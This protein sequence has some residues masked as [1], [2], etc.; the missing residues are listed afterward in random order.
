[1]EDASVVH[2]CFTGK[3][4]YDLFCVFD[5]HGSRHSAAYCAQHL[6]ERLAKKLK[7]GARPDTALRD[8]FVQVFNLSSCVFVSSVFRLVSSS[9]LLSSLT[10]T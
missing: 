3:D 10:Q 9:S 6:P 7:D 1:M 8:T 5:G 2:G 4:D